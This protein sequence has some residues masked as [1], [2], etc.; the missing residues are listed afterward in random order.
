MTTRVGSWTPSGDSAVFDAALDDMEAAL[1]A[2]VA[3]AARVA[4]LLQT[5]KDSRPYF[6]SAEQFSRLLM[7]CFRL[8]GVVDTVTIKAGNDDDRALSRIHWMCPA[9]V[10]Q[11]LF[12][13][14]SDARAF[15]ERSV[16]HAR[17]LHSDDIAGRTVH[18]QPPPHVPLSRS[19]VA[20]LMQPYFDWLSRRSTQDPTAHLMVTWNAVS[21]PLPPFDGLFW[22]W[23]DQRGEGEDL[24]LALSL[25]DLRERQQQRL[26]WS[27]F[28]TRLVPLLSHP[29]VLVSAHAAAFIGSLYTDIEDRMFGKG[30]WGGARI[31]GHIARLPNHRR[32]VAGA[33]LHGIDAMDPD[34][35]AEVEAIAPKLDLTSWVIAVLA[36]QGPDPV[37]PGVQMF[38][39]SLHEKF[40]EDVAMVNRLIDEGHHWI[41]WM[42]ITELDPPAD[43]MEGPI[44]RLATQGDDK[45]RTSATMLLK[46]LTDTSATDADPSGGP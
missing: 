13:G 30:S 6:E 28:E 37:I 35:F 36:D 14:R 22:E 33:F 23:M 38:W 19:E 11:S 15:I 1:A 20:A 10:E 18:Y 26:S 25:C 27:D 8:M 46:K 9:L 31:L 32:A 21:K 12:D 24:R 5:L 7:L 44:R 4:A 34:G 17:V 16:D 43:G 2:N 41:A 45:I 3:D 39:F 40:C 29:N 42:C